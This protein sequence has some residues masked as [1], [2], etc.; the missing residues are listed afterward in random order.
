MGHSKDGWP[1]GR[2]RILT[3]LMAMPPA[4]TMPGAAPSPAVS[5]VKKGLL[6]AGIGVIL[7]SILHLFSPVGWVIGGIVLVVGSALVFSR[8]SAWPAHQGSVTAGFGMI[9]VGYIIGVI[10][11]VLDP[12]AF[13]VPLNVLTT[14]DAIQYAL[15]AQLVA[16]VVTEIGVL[17]LPW[18]LAS[19]RSKGLIAAGAGLSIVGFLAI[20]VLEL[21]VL[22]V[23][24]GSVTPDQRTALL[25]AATIGTFV[26]GIMG[27]VGYFLARGRLPVAAP[28]TAM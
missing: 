1:Y 23:A 28:A 9:I 10:A 5:R 17:V 27:G 12:R 19:G 15:I 6:V 14:V 21:G 20:A 4:Q 2:V 24:G 8:R 3:E 16:G 18:R 25:T 26:G 22:G 13:I 7:A 11:D